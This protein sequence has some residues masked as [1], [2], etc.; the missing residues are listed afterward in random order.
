MMRE[1][2]GSGRSGGGVAGAKG[3][4]KQLVGYWVK[5]GEG[6]AAGSAELRK[7]WRSGCRVY[8]AG[9]NDKDGGIAADAEWKV[10]RKG[11][12]EPEVESRSRVEARSPMEGGDRG[13]LE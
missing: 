4:R 8:G 5:R 13:D 10:D 1:H 12:P 9:C 2:H 6:V 11:L 7:C 3:G